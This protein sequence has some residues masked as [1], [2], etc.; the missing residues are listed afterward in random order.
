MFFF[1]FAIPN[2]FDMKVR[3]LTMAACAALL[4]SQTWDSVASLTYSDEC[5]AVTC[6]TEQVSLPPKKD[7]KNKPPKDGKKPPKKGLRPDGSAKGDS[8]MPP[9]PP[10]GFANG[11]SLMPPPPPGG[12]APG[13]SLMPPPPPQDGDGPKFTPSDSLRVPPPA[14]PEG[15]E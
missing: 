6:A 5:D 1:N 10:D 4:A 9:P 14:K 3:I 12:F 11:D 7:K 13:D 15:E 2:S 8:L